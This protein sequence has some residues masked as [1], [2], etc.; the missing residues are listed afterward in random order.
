MTYNYTDYFNGPTLLSPNGGELFTT[1]DI[2]ITWLEPSDINAH[3]Q[4]VWYEILF[5]ESYSKI[6]AP[7]WITIAKLTTGNSSFTWNVSEYI[8]GH[9]CRIGI[10][11]INSWGQTSK[12]SYSASNF[13]IQDRKLPTP[14]V[15]EPT[16]NTNY[17]SYVPFIL[18]KKGIN[19]SMFSKSLLSNIL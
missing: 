19:R 15:I 18:D 17:Y 3:D 9:R 13:S 10:R 16:R 5:A 11:A 12:I 2:N 8:K 7:N 1:R 14:A 6:K 4:L